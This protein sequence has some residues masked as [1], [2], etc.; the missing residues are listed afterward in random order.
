[1]ASSIKG[2]QP[3]IKKA[4]TSIS[5]P[6]SIFL[7]RRIIRLLKPSFLSED[8][9]LKRVLT[10]QSFHPALCYHP[11]ILF[12]KKLNVHAGLLFT[13]TLIIILKK[14]IRI[15]LLNNES[16]Q[17]LLK[18]L[19]MQACFGNGMEFWFEDPYT[20]IKSYSIPN[21]PKPKGRIAVYT[22]LT[23]SYDDVH[24]ILYKEEGVD[25]ILFT[26][27]PSLTCKTW[28]IVL[29]ES[30]LD[31]VLLSR[32]IKML[33]QKYLENN[34]E[35]SIYVDAN[36]VI[37]GEIT[38]L[39]R[40]LSA[41]KPLA[42]SR[43]CERDSVKKEGE[44]ITRVFGIDNDLVLSQLNRYT[45]EG[46]KDDLG[47]A[48]CNILVRRHQDSSVISLMNLWWEEFCRGVKRDQISLMPC[49][50]KLHFT[51]LSW[52]DSGCSRHNQ[53]CKV[54]AHKKN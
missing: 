44:A 21:T 4:L 35:T 50:N 29:I 52:M 34:Y 16:G 24:E 20:P 39:T 26:N 37:Y 11:S 7:F 30:G 31:N 51:G 1:M 8:E 3:G 10:A 33:P 38:E 36:I 5:S 46:F 6:L 49:I 14:C 43:H 25:Y 2:Y 28:D 13:K 9:K 19:G 47:L 40:F 41:G 53:F 32:E 54:V 17:E 27:N 45:E 18:E 22:V 12:G 42:I 48:E 23:G 15:G